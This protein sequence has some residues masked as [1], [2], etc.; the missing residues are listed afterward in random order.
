VNHARHAQ[1][2]SPIVNRLVVIGLGLIGGSFAKGLR[3]AGLCREVVGFDLDARSRELAVE[4]GVVD[5]CAATLA[6]ACHGADVIQLATPILALER[7]LAELANIELGDAVITD[8]GS[9]KGNVVRCARKVFG[10]MPS[11]FVPGHPIAGSELSGVTAANSALFRRHKVILTPLDNT[12]P[13]ALT[14][15][16][17]L[18]SALGAD[19]EH[20]EVTHHDEVLAATSHLPHLLA[21]GLV[22]S[23]AKRHENLEIFRYAAGG[24]R[25][26]TRIAGSDPVM[27]HDIFLANREAVLQTLDAFRADLDALRAAV[28]EGDGH[29][30]LGVFTRAKAAREHFSKILA[31]RAYV[32]VMHSNDLVW[33]PDRP[34]ACARRQIHFSPL[35]HARLSCRG[36]D[37]SRRLPGGRRCSGDHSG[38]PGHGRRH[39]GSASGARDG[40]WC[41]SARPQGPARADLPRQLRNL[42]AAAVRFACGAAVRY[43][44][45]G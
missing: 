20:M 31:R 29:K 36:R 16:S 6:E 19:V 15:V 43:D 1:Q 38:V 7:L 25:D 24:F 13:Q 30:L 14:L 37:G 18:W 35:D 33:Q 27:W 3:E 5:R 4:L 21:F 40:P 2:P 11:R 41:R 26:F 34:S 22:D 45:D 39:R 12:D 32:D 8:V 42:H 44:V 23:L 9:A 17:K 10:N 28:D